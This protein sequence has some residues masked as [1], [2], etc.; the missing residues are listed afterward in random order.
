MRKEGLNNFLDRNKDRIER[1]IERHVKREKHQE[2]IK[3]LEEEEKEW[4]IARKVVLLLKEEGYVPNGYTPRPSFKEPDQLP[5]EEKSCP[6]CGEA[7]Y[8]SEAAEWCSTWGENFE[9][10]SECGYRLMGG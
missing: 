3:I 7:L 6:Q 9:L 4:R 2:S 10:D 1:R 8:S 5:I